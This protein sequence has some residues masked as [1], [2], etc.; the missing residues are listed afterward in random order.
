MPAQPSWDLRFLRTV[1]S[2]YVSPTESG[3]LP[4]LSSPLAN[5][6]KVWLSRA[7]DGK[8]GNLTA[9]HQARRPTPPNLKS[10]HSVPRHS[11]LVSSTAMAQSSNCSQMKM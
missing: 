5:R 3:H 10:G 7:V 6:P 8:G 2:G 4:A 1:P 9:A 11:P